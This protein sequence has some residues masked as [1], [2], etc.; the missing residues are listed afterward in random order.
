MGGDALT[1]A[2]RSQRARF[3]AK[4]RWS[5]EDPAGTGIRAQAGLRAKFDREVREHEPGLSDAEYARRA[6]CAYRAY[7]QRLAYRSAM[8]RRAKAGK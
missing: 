5:Q 8:V 4:I 3:A 2:L 6:E 1:P 7:M